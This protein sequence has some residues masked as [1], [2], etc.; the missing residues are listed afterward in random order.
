MKRLILYAAFGLI[1]TEM[2]H[3]SFEDDFHEKLMRSGWSRCLSELN[4]HSAD[5]RRHILEKALLSFGRDVPPRQPERQRNFEIAQAALLATPGH[6]QYYQGKIEAMRAEAL[7]NA[8]KT[9]DELFEMQANDQEVV[10]EWS[11]SSYCGTTAFPIL[12]QMPSPE[13]VAVLGHFLNDPEGRDGKKITGRAVVRSTGA[14]LTINAEGAAK[15]IRNLG[16]DHPP[17]KAPVGREREGL[18]EGEVDAWKDWWNEVKDGKRTYRFIGSNIEYGPNGPASKEAIGR[19][20]RNQKRDAE[21]SA[22]HKKATSVTSPTP[23]I[24]QISKPSSIAGILAA[25]ALVTAAFW[26]FLKGRNW[27]KKME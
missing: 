24:T 1:V 17:F 8:K 23:V 3:G 15:A 10:N 12:A 21:R 22:G 7:S 25:C 26:Y 5:E 9:D 19:A 16:I 4:Q 11:Y 20:E 13:T 6:A 14:S 27:R 2:L 18:S